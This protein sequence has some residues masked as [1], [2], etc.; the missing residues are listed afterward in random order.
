M[1]KKRQATKRNKQFKTEEIV[2]LLKQWPHK[3]AWNRI[4]A[5]ILA[6]LLV[7]V[8]FMYAL[9]QFYIYKHRDVPVEFGA[10]F[11]PRYARYYDLDAEETLAAIIDDLGVKRL[12]LVTYWDVGE[13]EEGRYDFSDFDW[14]LKMAEEKGAKVSLALGLRQPRWPECHMPKWAEKM[15]MEEW[16]PKLHDYIAAIVERYK[17]SPALDSYQ[18]ENEFFLK[19]FGICPD[20]TRERLV[21]EYNLVKSIDPDTPLVVT[22]SNNAIGMPI[23]EPTPDMW[24]I[25][26]YKRVWDATLTK[27]YFEYPL[28]AWYYGFRAGWTE[29]TRGRS[30]FIHE[31]QAEA[32]TPPEFGSMKGASLEEQDKSLDPARLRDRIEYGRATGMKKI[33]LWGV[34]WWYWRKV[35]HNDPALWDTAREELNRIDRL[36]EKLLQ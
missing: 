9:A 33:D 19:A 13:P 5:S 8:I 28:P 14:Q 21:S 15:P 24:A 4:C 31:L 1:T 7:S 29:M 6:V 25:S 35:K 22:M 2:R 27:R 17:D 3:N 23:F 26:V 11:I 16:S 34:E 10:T 20:F 12:R 18:L 36:N 32:W 30:S